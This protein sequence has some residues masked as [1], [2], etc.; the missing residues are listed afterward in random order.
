[1]SKSRLIVHRVSIFGTSTRYLAEIR[2]RG[3]VPRNSFNLERL[4]TVTSTGAALSANMYNWF[5]EIGFSPHVQLVSMSGGTDIAGS[6][7]CWRKSFASCVRWRDSGQSV[8]HGRRNF[9]PS[10]NAGVPVE[11]LDLPGELVCTKPFPSQP[12]EFFGVGGNE[13]YQKSY[14]ERFG[15][16]VWCQRD[17][18]QFQKDT[19][20]LIMLGRSDGVLNPSGVRFGS[21]EIYAVT[22]EFPEVE[23]SICVGQRRMSDIDERFLLFVK[24]KTSEAFTADLATRLK[25]AIRKRYSSR[26]VPK[27]VFEVADIPYTVNG[28]KCEINVKQIVSGQ[29]GAVSGTVSNPSSLDLYRKYANLPVEVERREPGS[30][31]L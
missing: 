3:I 30:S 9:D 5:Y 24:M 4:R 18:I 27:H 6:C 17:F 22:E 26:H 14:F 1:M 19:E 23:D 13:R 15:D 16:T 10:Q 31:K 11:L 20:G 8:R 29:V 21:S 25:L 2:A 28:K 12:L 7:T